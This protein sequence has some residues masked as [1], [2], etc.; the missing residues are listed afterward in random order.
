MNQSDRRYLQVHRANPALGLSQFLEA[1]R[2]RLVE[3][4]DFEFSQVIHLS[5]KTPISFNLFFQCLFSG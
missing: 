2:C 5:S 3:I 4:E 1:Y